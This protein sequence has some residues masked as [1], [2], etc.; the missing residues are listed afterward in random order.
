MRIILLGPQGS[1]KGTQA[2]LLSKKLN[3]PKITTGD[4]LRDN[5]KEGT[6]LGKLA[7][8][9]MNKGKLIPDETINKIVEERL[10]KEN[11]KKGFVLDGYPRNVKQAEMLKKMTD[12]DFVIEIAISDKEAIKRISGRRSCKCGEVYH[13]SYNPSKVPETCD[14]CGSRLFQRDDDKEELVKKRLE[15]YHKETEPLTEFYKDKHIRI[16]GE[17]SIEKVFED[18]IMKALF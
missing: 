17:Q 8:S 7:S 5:E 15:I 6:K 16:D 9:Y 12:I 3:V 11:C 2:G 18:I 1:G 14:K 10:N 4:I 13:I